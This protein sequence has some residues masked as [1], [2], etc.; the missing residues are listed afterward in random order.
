[1]FTESLGKRRPL[2]PADFVLHSL[3]HT[4]LTRL[5]ESGT[6]AFTIMRVADHSSIVV[7]QRYIHPT[8]ESVER[9][10][11]GAATVRGFRAKPAKTSA[12]RFNIRYARADGIRKLLKGL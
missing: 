7:S 8:P 6:D 9:A 5:G 4:M 2:F 3:R 10:F 1:L 12:T 11:R